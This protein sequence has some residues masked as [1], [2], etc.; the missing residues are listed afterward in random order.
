MKSVEFAPS[1]RSIYLVCYCTYMCA[2]VFVASLFGLLIWCDLHSQKQNK[3]FHSI[4]VSPFPLK[5]NQIKP[6]QRERYKLSEFCMC[7]KCFVLLLFL[8]LLLFSEQPNCEEEIGPKWEH[9]I[10]LM[11]RFQSI[12]RHTKWW[13]LLQHVP[14]LPVSRFVI[15]IILLNIMGACARLRSSLLYKSSYELELV[16]D[17]FHLLLPLPLIWFAFKNKTATTLKR[18]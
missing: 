18:T 7:A 10:V 1:R 2:C 4:H 11:L 15:I 13:K 9:W 6:N 16:L 17:I 12:T 5:S 8:L 3:H 14:L